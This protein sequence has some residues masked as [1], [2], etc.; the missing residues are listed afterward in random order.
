M[1][2]RGRIELGNS[3]CVSCGGKADEIVDGAPVCTACK[4]EVEKI[5]S[6]TEDATALAA[7]NYKL[8]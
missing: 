6:E 7:M 1:E 2:K 4:G 5:A 8:K 3:P